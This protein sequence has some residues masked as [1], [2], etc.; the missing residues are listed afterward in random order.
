[1]THL[2]V[3]IIYISIKNEF[4]GECVGANRLR[5]WARDSFRSLVILPVLLGCHR[6]GG[7]GGSGYAGIYEIFVPYAKV[8]YNLLVGTSR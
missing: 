5:N 8:A 1:M 6:Q 2:L 3:V 7:S 4:L